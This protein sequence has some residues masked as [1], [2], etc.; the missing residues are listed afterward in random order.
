MKTIHSGINWC[1]ASRPARQEGTVPQPAAEPYWSAVDGQVSLY[2]GD[3]LHLMAG[4]AGASFDAVV[5]DPGH[6][7]ASA[8]AGGGAPYQAWCQAWA[9]QCLRLLRPGGHLLAFG[10]PRAGHRLTAGIEDAG[11]EIRGTITWIYAS[12]RPRSRDVAADVE[13][14]TGDSALAD[15]WDGWRTALKPACKPVTVARKPLAGTVAGNLLE[16]GTGAINVGACRVPDAAAGAEGRWPPDL[17]LSHA[18][19]CQPGCCAPGCPAAEL[20]AQAGAAGGFYPVFR[21]EPEVPARERP[22]G[23]GGNS[24]P[25]GKPLGLVCWL[26]RLVARP[27]ASILDPFAGSGATGQAALI[28][29]LRCVL[30]EQDQGHADLAVWRLTRPVQQTL[31]F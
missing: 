26:A 2:L 5:C 17:V 7:L 12:G 11:F 25:D 19:A 22:G 13:R 6:A 20:E 24:G 1:R 21:F 23:P 18:P 16:F 8:P 3:S 31:G 27:G 30:I 15:E 4:L 28:E 9:A 29:G 14:L 10:S